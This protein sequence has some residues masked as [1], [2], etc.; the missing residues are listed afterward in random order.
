MPG[1]KDRET[2]VDQVITLRNQGYSNSQIIETLKQQNYTLQEISDAINQSEIKTNIE[3]QYY[4]LSDAPS[5][6]QKSLEFPNPPEFANQELSPEQ[7]PVQ[8]QTS[9]Y[10]SYMAEPQRDSYTE[11]IEEI[12]E[13]IIKEK[14]EDLLKD[15]GDFAVWK[16]KVRTD[17]LSIKQELLRTQERFENLQKSVLGK[18]AEYDSDVREIGTE[19]KAMEKVFE[20]IIEP[21]TTNIKELNK[22][23]KELKYKTKK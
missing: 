22:I 3:Q 6:S 23:T 1:K 18:V 17:I 5:P 20:K 7:T 21:L 12:A 19:L 11:K 9:G 16:E 15:I 2:P 14:W 8:R 13:S 4:D 10:Q